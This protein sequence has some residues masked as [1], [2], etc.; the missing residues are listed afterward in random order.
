MTN[1]KGA[2]MANSTS[3][4]DLSGALLFGRRN[5]HAATA[6]KKYRVGREWGA[7]WG[8]ENGLRPGENGS[9]IC[10]VPMPHIYKAHI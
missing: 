6:P 8:T 5:Q 1:E 7:H 4:T 10:I 2:P 3:S 9:Y